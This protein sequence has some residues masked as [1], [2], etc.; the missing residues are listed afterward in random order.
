MAEH[1]LAGSRA[2]S[3]A[4]ASATTALSVGLANPP[5]PPYRPAT[6]ARRSS[7]RSTRASFGTDRQTWA[8]TASTRARTG[9]A[10]ALICVDPLSAARASAAERAPSRSRCLH[11]VRSSPLRRYTTYECADGKYVAVCAVEPQFY[12]RLLAGSWTR[13]RN[14]R[15]RVPACP[16]AAALFTLQALRLASP[17]GALAAQ[18]WGFRRMGFPGRAIARSGVQ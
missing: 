10:L 7:S 1:A 9:T 13:C 17:S 16:R 6:S 12:V 3:A 2:K 8:A 11:R 14:L 15:S 4:A 18:A 5:L